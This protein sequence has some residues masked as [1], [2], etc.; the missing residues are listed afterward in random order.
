MV[1]SSQYWVLTTSS[2]SY[3]YSLSSLVNIWGLYHLLLLT[4]ESQ[5]RLGEVPLT[6][7]NTRITLI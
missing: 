6:I 1:Q 7:C 2:K 5:T 3:I 4:L